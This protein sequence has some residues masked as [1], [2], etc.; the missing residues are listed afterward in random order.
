MRSIYL[1]R[2]QIVLDNPTRATQN[3]IRSTFPHAP[4]KS[5]CY[6]Y[7][8]R[9][10]CAQGTKEHIGRSHSSEG[11]AGGSQCMSVAHLSSVSVPHRCMGVLSGF[12]AR[13]VSLILVGRVRV[14]RSALSSSMLT[15]TRQ[16]TGMTTWPGKCMRSFPMLVP[17]FTR[18]ASYFTRFAPSKSHCHAWRQSCA[19]GT[20]ERIGTFR[21]SEAPAGSCACDAFGAC[22]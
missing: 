14:V 22:P 11:P 3:C 13:R 6:V 4:C 20:K 10:S 19:Q 5:H 18:L 17:I 1:C 9:Q 8:W 2:G 16:S 21:S 15:G 12:H 7:A